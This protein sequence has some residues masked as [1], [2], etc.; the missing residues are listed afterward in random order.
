MRRR[1][2]E[3]RSRPSEPRA[4]ADV[5]RGRLREVASATWSKP[6]SDALTNS[7]SWVC[8]EITLKSPRRG[9]RQESETEKFPEDT[10]AQVQRARW[11]L[12]V[13]PG[14][15]WKKLWR[16]EPTTVRSRPAQRRSRGG[17]SATKGGCWNRRVSFR[18]RWHR[19]RGFDQNWSTSVRTEDRWETRGR[20]R[21][22]ELCTSPPAS[23]CGWP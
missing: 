5:Q 8:S 11:S 20:K 14:S 22:A 1:K 13:L 9:E 7:P 10:L 18:G 21:T 17:G 4:E 12:P 23:A 19:E 15:L 2:E 6:R 3:Y 16:R